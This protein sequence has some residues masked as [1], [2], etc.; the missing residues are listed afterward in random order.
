LLQNNN[1]KLINGIQCNV[2]PNL[3]LLTSNNHNN[4]VRNVLRKLLES[5]LAELLLSTSLYLPMDIRNKKF[6]KNK[7]RNSSLNTK[8]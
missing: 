6:T 4:F 3:V 5:E 1:K 8:N 7:Y 2:K